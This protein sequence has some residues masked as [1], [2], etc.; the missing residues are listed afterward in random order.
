MSR[1]PKPYE[2]TKQHEIVSDIDLALE[3]ISL[4]GYTVIEGVLSA[5]ECEE[6]RTRLDAVYKTQEDQFGQKRLKSIHEMNLARCPLAYDSYFLDIAARASILA[7]VQKLIGEY[8]LLHLQNGI[9]NKPDEEHNQGFWHRDLPYQNFIISHPI[10]VSALYCIDDFNEQRGATRVIPGSHKIEMLPSQQFVE[11]NQKC[12]VAGAGSVIL[13]DAMLF[14][15]AGKNLSGEVRRG[16][17]HV[18]TIPII[19]QQID[20]PRFL[21][22]RFEEDAF[23]RKFLGYDSEVSPSVDLYR[24]KR[25]KKLTQ[26]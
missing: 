6:T 21:E 12:V 2:K 19:K 5:D 17:N 11:K 26:I 24:Q 4:L 13:F 18:Y 3:E 25:V 16:I 14:H 23:H 15:R 20:L 8:V 1:T 7:I 10:A 9:M 22:G